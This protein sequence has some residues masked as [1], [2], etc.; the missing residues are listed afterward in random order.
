MVGVFQVRRSVLALSSSA[1]MFYTSVSGACCNLAQIASS[2]SP[3]QYCI[4]THAHTY[5]V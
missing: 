4:H 1:A 2:D 3:G 5:K